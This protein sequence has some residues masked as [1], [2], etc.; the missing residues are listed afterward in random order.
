MAHGRAEK[1]L[2]E[3]QPADGQRAAVHFGAVTPERVW[4]HQ[5]EVKSAISE[6]LTKRSCATAPCRIPSWSSLKTTRRPPMQPSRKTEERH[7]PA[8]PT[9]PD[10]F[11]EEE[12]DRE[13][14]HKHA[15]AAGHQPVRVLVENAADPALP[16]KK[17][18]L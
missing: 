12:P 14:G 8:H 17:N 18:M 1:Q 13:A 4:I 16:R 15:D 10:A 3:D 2:A 9:Q 11:L 6:T 7:D 5:R